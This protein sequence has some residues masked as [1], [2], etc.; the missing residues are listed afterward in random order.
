MESSNVQQ[1]IQEHFDNIFGWVSLPIRD[2]TSINQLN[3]W[4]NISVAFLC[5]VGRVCHSKERTK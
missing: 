1:F 5:A 4:E 2:D 3:V